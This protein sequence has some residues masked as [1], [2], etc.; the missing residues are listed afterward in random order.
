MSG[1]CLKYG[2]IYSASDEDTAGQNPAAVFHLT[3]DGKIKQLA[4]IP[5]LSEGEGALMYTG[6]FYIEPLEVQI[7]FLKASDAEKWLE[8]LILRHTE[9]VRQITDD[10]FVTAEIKEVNA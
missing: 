1:Y 9:R 4:H 7:E 5:A 8:A 6:E 10:L 3:A 2:R